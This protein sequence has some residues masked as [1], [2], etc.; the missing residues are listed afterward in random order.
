MLDPATAGTVLA[1]LESAG[2]VAGCCDLAES[3]ATPIDK[4]IATKVEK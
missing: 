2:G 3:A 1:G 4:K